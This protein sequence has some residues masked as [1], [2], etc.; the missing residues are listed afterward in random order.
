MSSKPPFFRQGRSDTCAFACLRMLLAHY[1]MEVTEEEL[2]GTVTMEPGAVHEELARLAE[3]CELRAE[4]RQLKQE[5]LRKLVA[6]EN[7]PIVSLNRLP[8]DRQFA[9]PAVIPIR[10]SSRFVILL[11]PLRGERRL[12]ICPP[13]AGEL[14]PGVP[15]RLIATELL[16]IILPLTV[17]RA[18]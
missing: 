6:S 18:L 2:L 5:D 13:L 17:F 11:D 15:T 14:G 3:E 8:I 16:F 12:S 9:I 4:I 10:V 7:F 1:G